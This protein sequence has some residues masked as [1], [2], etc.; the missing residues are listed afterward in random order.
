MALFKSIKKCK[1][2]DLCH[3]QPP[4]L[5]SKKNADVFWIGLSAVKTEV[6]NDGPLS[7]NTKTGKLVNEIELLL[8]H[9]SFYRTNV[10]KCLPLKNTKIRYPSM[11]EMEL[12]YRHLT[13]EINYFSPKIVLLLGKQV[14]SFVLKNKGVGKVDLDGKFNYRPIFIEGIYYLPVHHPSYVL[15]YKRKQVHN[16]ITK[17][18]QVLSRHHYEEAIVQ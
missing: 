14:A 5:Q 4:L 10:V 8:N 3:N 16:Y 12:C 2:C 1:I 11:Q 6:S 15:I 9:I 7:A 13:R 17:I 18:K